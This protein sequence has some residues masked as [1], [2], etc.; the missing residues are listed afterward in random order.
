MTQSGI[1]PTILR[2][3]EQ[4]VNQ[5]LHRARYTLGLS[6]NTL[7]NSRCVPVWG[8]LSRLRYLKTH[9]TGLEGL[10]SVFISQKLLSLNIQP[11]HKIGSGIKCKIFTNYWI[12]F[13]CE[14]CYVVTL[15]KGVFV[16]QCLLAYISWQRRESSF[17]KILSVRNFGSWFDCWNY[18]FRISRYAGLMFQL[19]WKE[20]KF[21]VYKGC[22]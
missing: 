18:S 16:T 3:V 4:C 1:E 13:Y 9:C 11:F 2:L 8:S 6:L 5:L 10:T 17:Y 22:G 15:W 19:V 21:E 7:Q 12:E 20:I 14:F